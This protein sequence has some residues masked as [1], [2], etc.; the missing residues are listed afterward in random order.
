MGRS[1]DI[2]L[3][4]LGFLYE[5]LEHLIF[6]SLHLDASLLDEDDEGGVF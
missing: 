3:S 1:L 5:V 6:P 2:D 4:L